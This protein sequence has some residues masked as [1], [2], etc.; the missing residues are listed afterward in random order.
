VPVF[1]YPPGYNYF[2][3][4]IFNTCCNGKEVGKKVAC[5]KIY[6]DTKPLK[7]KRKGKNFRGFSFN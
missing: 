1:P 5:L 7:N 6:G 4:Y 3:V 2:E